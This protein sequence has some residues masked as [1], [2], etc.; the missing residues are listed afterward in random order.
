MMRRRSARNYQIKRNKWFDFQRKQNG[1]SP[2]GLERRPHTIQAMRKLTW[3][4]LHGMMRTARARRIPW[5][6]RNGTLSGFSTCTGM[7][8]NG[9]RIGGTEKTFT[10][11]LQ[12]KIRKAL[13]RVPIVCCAAV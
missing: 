10:P 8:G 6:K 4:A 11:N 2:V 12:L 13:I 9:V 3:L 5:A 7:F 1:N